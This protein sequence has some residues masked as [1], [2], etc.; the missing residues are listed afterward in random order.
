[1]LRHSYPYQCI[2]QP[3]ERFF[4]RPE[5]PLHFN[6]PGCE[7][8]FPLCTCRGLVRDL[9]ARHVFRMAALEG[10]ASSPAAMVSLSRIYAIF[11]CTDTCSHAC[12]Q[13]I[14]I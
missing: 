2:L 12:T 13:E 9:S 4:G 8:F 14:P 7:G 5:Y 3:Q 6:Y 1:M 11:L 10:D